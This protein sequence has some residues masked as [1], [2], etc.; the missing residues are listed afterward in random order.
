LSDG[1][2]TRY[3]KDALLENGGE[4]T[5][6]CDWEVVAILASA[7]PNEPMPLTMARNFLQKPGGTK[8]VYTADFYRRNT[9]DASERLAKAAPAL[10]EACIAARMNFDARQ[11]CESPVCELLDRAIEAAEGTNQR[12]SL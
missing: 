2:A 1:W 10:L 12:A 4:R 7:I 11:A 8:S 5:T 9:M 3:H 6:N